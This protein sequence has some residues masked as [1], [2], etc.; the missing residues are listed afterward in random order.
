MRD[1]LLRIKKLRRDTGHAFANSYQELL[2]SPFSELDLKNRWLQH[3]QNHPHFH[4]EGWYNP[5]PDGIICSFGKNADNYAALRRPSFRAPSSWPTETQYDAED[6]SL[7]YASPIDRSSNLIGDWGL[8]LYSGSKTDIKEYFENTLLATLHVAESARSGMA[9]RELYAIALETGTRHG[10]SNTNV[11]SISDMA[12]TNIG[13]T[14]PLS[15]IDTPCRKEI[16]NAR[17]N[18][19]RR[20]AISAARIFINAQEEQIIEDNM[21]LVIEPRY[22]TYKYPDTLFHMTLVFINGEKEICHEYSPALQATGM[23]YLIRHLL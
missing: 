21:A 8:S 7:V 14:I 10:L 18:N 23:D 9:F 17:S 4:D 5:P 12:G 1:T 11:Q 16:K 2:K 3:L 13:H 20:D 6:I 15:Y 19:E 22:S